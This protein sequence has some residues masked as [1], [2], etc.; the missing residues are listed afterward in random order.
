VH[1]TPLLPVARIID[2]NEANVKTTL[3]VAAST[4]GVAIP[5]SLTPPP[6]LVSSLSAPPRVYQTD[7]GALI[8]QPGA[9]SLPSELPCKHILSSSEASATA[10]ASSSKSVNDSGSSSRLLRPEFV[11]KLNASL[12]IASN[13]TNTNNNSSGNNNDGK[14]GS[15]SGAQPNERLQLANNYLLH[16]HGDALPLLEV[17]IQQLEAAYSPPEWSRVWTYVRSKS[18]SLS[19]PTT[20]ENEL[21]QVY[22]QIASSFNGHEIMVRINNDI[23]NYYRNVNLNN[24]FH[25]QEINQR[26]TGVFVWQ[27]VATPSWLS[28]YD[29]RTLP[30]YILHSIGISLRHM[31]LIRHRLGERCPHLS[32]RLLV[33]MATRTAKQMLRKVMRNAAKLFSQINDHKSGGHVGDEKKASTPLP[34]IKLDHELELVR[35]YTI[36]SPR[37]LNYSPSS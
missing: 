31:G 5:S 1:A 20:L 11:A 6:L 15:K 35:Q 3:R 22:Q 9:S 24:G 4:L 26:I 33:E 7:N 8:F 27:R 18:V 23:G 16:Y 28:A 2:D 30:Q 29:P 12:P 32:R 25:E 36:Y 13:P 19:L 10:T 17:A 34:K 37:Y 21:R 14:N